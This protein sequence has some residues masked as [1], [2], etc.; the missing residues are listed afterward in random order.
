VNRHS[1]LLVCCSVCFL[2]V[3]V[4]CE[5]GQSSGNGK[6]VE[7]KKSEPVLK[8]SD[9]AQ[10]VMT[11]AVKAHGGEK[12]FGRWSCG[13]F[14]YTTNGGFLPIQSDGYTIEDT[15]QLPG[16]F[17]RVTHFGE[18]PKRTTM[19]FVIN[20]GKGWT[21]KG[22]G[23]AQPEDNDFTKKTQHPFAEFC[24]LKPLTEMS[25]RLTKLT[26]EKIEGYDAMGVRAQS[27]TLGQVDFYF[28]MQTG[29][30]LKSKKSLAHQE[31][32]KSL[33]M[34]SILEDYK[35]VESVK[36]PMRIRG[37]QNG[38]LTLE[39]KLVDVKFADKYEESTFA[40]P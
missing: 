19:I 21:K 10:V 39:V 34:E 13:Y 35:D 27:E 11:K 3:A 2:F 18:G 26:N 1:V 32:G 20:D 38:E 16:H 31:T 30:L 33:V 14:K 9:D 29:L 23:P 36:V 12:A 5:H 28:A 22:D 17:K 7:E 24:N 6:P 8:E 40:K 4:G 15:F 25:V 37:F